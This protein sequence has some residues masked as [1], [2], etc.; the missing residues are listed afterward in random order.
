MAGARKPG[1]LGLD[2]DGEP[3]DDGTLCRGTSRSPGPLGTTRTDLRRALNAMSQVKRDSYHLGGDISAQEMEAREK[4]RETIVRLLTRLKSE[5]TTH[6]MAPL[7]VTDP[8]LFA[9]LSADQWLDSFRDSRRDHEHFR[10]WLSEGLKQ[11]VDAVDELKDFKL[12]DVPRQVSAWSKIRG[13]AWSVFTDLDVV[14]GLIDVVNAVNL[15]ARSRTLDDRQ[16]DIDKRYAYIKREIQRCIRSIHSQ[17]PTARVAETQHSNTSQPSADSPDAARGLRVESITDP[18]LPSKILILNAPSNPPES[19]HGAGLTVPKAAGEA[20]E[21]IG[22]FKPRRNK[23]N[24]ETVFKT[25]DRKEFERSIKMAEDEINKLS[26]DDFLKRLD[27]LDPELGGKGAKAIRNET[28]NKAA[29]EEALKKWK[30]I[31]KEDMPNALPH[32]A[33]V[34]LEEEPN[35]PLSAEEARASVEREMGGHDFASRLDLTHRA[36]IGGGGDPKVFGGPGDSSIN[37]SIGGQWRGR[38][39]ALRKKAEKAK[40]DGKKK[41]DVELKVCP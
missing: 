39:K 13:T 2:G 27:D 8:F 9:Q 36:D 38:L 17:R 21:E 25:M 22:C 32:L 19:L 35:L 26:P 7:A 28:A 31:F 29:Y 18:V 16:A 40:R 3:I 20:D 41:M 33:Q 30:T 10:D 6:V 4:M 5:L 15:R 1:P 12:E 34:L 37:R 24:Q 14:R 11:L 23:P